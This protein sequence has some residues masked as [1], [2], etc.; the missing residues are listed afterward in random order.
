MLEDALNARKISSKALEAPNRENRRLTAEASMRQDE[1]LKLKS[2][3]DESVKGK[4]EVEAIKDSVMAEKENL[5]NK[6]YDADANFVANFH[7]I[8]AYTKISNYFASVG[9]QEVITALRSKHPDLD[10]SSFG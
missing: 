6:H 10:L 1:M 9:Q 3:L 8:E 2:D 5:A 4:V 7:L